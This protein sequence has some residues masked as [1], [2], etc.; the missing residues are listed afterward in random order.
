MGRTDPP[1]PPK[2]LRERISYLK[3]K[4]RECRVRAT[5]AFSAEGRITFLSLASLYED[6]ARQ[7][8]EIRAYRQT[9]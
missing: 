2:Q 6:L 5:E 7:L 1:D 4:A 3:Q 9:K 8:N